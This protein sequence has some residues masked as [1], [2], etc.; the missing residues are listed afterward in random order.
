MV[1]AI[2][3]REQRPLEFDG[4]ETAVTTLKVGDYSIVGY[5]S[6]V[7]C[8]RKSYSD[9]WSSMSNGRGRFERCVERLS[10]LNRAAIIIECSMAEACVQPPQIQR[11]NTASVVGGLISWSCRYNIPVFFCEDRAYAARVVL[12]F[13]ASY[14]KHRDAI[15]QST[16]ELMHQ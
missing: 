16:G 3:T 5:E 15:V 10:N 8:E 11:V 6:E 14:L 9:L 7:A 12:R 13:L 2:D 1:I 4:M